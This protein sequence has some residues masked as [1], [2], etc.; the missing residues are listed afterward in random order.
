M[1]LSM[2]HRIA[3]ILSGIVLCSRPLPAQTPE[4]SPTPTPQIIKIN[5]LWGAS[6][7]VT[8][9]IEPG[10]TGSAIGDVPEDIP[11]RACVVGSKGKNC[12]VA[13][14]KNYAYGGASA[15]IRE[16]GNGKSTL[17]ILA[18][19]S[20]VSDSSTKIVLLGIDAHGRLVNLLPRAGYTM[21]DSYRFWTD[22]SISEYRL[23]TV[24][25]FIWGKDDGH[26]GSH[27]FDITSFA[28][29][30]G[31]GE[32]AQVDTFRT[33]RRVPESEDLHKA[34]ET[35]LNAQ[36]AVVKA[37]LT[38]NSSIQNACTALKP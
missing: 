27:Y 17:Q 1:T 15:S 21:Q 19:F 7:P 23:L 30:P 29:C 25:N 22:A 4:A 6:A 14:D 9:R 24:A 12:F 26:F 3:V 20:G 36:M 11:A 16:I 10:V 8:V 28:F 31:P 33:K 2:L 13:Q 35:E 32:Y 18:T 37:R 34:G 38:K 5:S